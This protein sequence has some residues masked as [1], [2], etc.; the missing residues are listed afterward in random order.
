MGS[1]IA[2]QLGTMQITELDAL[3]VM[4]INSTLF[5]FAQKSLVLYIPSDVSCL[6]RISIY[7]GYLA[8]WLSS[9]ISPSE[10]IQ[11]FTLLRLPSH[12][13]VPHLPLS[14]RWFLPFDCLPISA[15]PF[16]IF[17]QSWEH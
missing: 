16:K 17:Y 6:S 9:A 11:G 13:C 10:H 12:L 2:S 7:G 8:G 4:G 5:G 1:H 14:S 3:E 15:F